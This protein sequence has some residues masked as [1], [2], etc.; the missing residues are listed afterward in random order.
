MHSTRAILLLALLPRVG[1]TLSPTR[2]ACSAVPRVPQ[3]AC[4][5]GW[6][7]AA[8]L[9]VLEP[10]LQ[11]CL[12][13]CFMLMSSC[14]ILLCATAR[15]W[16]HASAG[17]ASLLVNIWTF[18]TSKLDLG[19][20]CP[21]SMTAHI[22]HACGWHQSW[23]LKSAWPASYVSSQDFQ[24]SKCQFAGHAGGRG[25]IATCLSTQSTILV[26][27]KGPAW[28]LDAQ[29][30]QRRPGTGDKS[31]TQAVAAQGRCHHHKHRLQGRC[32]APPAAADPCPPTWEHARALCV[33][34]RAVA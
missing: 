19:E 25:T 32:M 10:A 28:Q 4:G 29:P 6:E 30:R 11:L 3:P 23:S 34:S 13:T 15:T 1:Q 7:P 12:R 33:P 21:P 27:E 24:P 20:S 26:N 2:P 31:V 17:C 9:Q 8:L 14:S 5:E 16:L 22:I 18:S